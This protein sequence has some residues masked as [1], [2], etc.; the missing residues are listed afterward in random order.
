[1]AAD[2]SDCSSEEVG[3][4]VG[5]ASLGNDHSNKAPQYLPPDKGVKELF[6]SFPGFG[7]PLPGQADATSGPSVLWVVS[8]TAPTPPLCRN[9]LAG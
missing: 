7:S 1:M 5:K 6:T 3:A 2:R 8:V 9:L 4:G